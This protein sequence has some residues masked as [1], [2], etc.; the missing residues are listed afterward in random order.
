MRIKAIYMSLAFIVLFFT[1]ASVFA[2]FYKYVDDKG[3]LHF[4]DDITKIPEKYQGQIKTY[5]ERFDDLPE[6]VRKKKLEKEREKQETEEKLRDKK[7][8]EMMNRWKKEREE[9]LAR[10]RSKA[11]ETPVKIINNQIFVPVKIGYEKKEMQIWLLLDT[12]ASIVAIHK[13][14]ADSL[15]IKKRRRIKARVAGGR[16]I[17]ARI[18]RVDFIEVGPHIKKNIKVGIY[19]FEG[20]TSS[21]AGLLGINFLKGLNYA[22]DFDKSVI[23]WKK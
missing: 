17:K 21:H 20:G 1:D 6:D 12:G 13:N 18:A 4:V 14:I 19:D 10:K 2:E 11:N 3:M 9:I 22:I 7:F 23:K 5:K 16:E 15:H 8:M